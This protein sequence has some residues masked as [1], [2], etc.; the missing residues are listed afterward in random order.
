MSPIANISKID[1]L[2]I[3]TLNILR[4]YN[5]QKH[6][7]K[8]KKNYRKIGIMYYLKNLLRKKDKVTGKRI[9]P[10][11]VKSKRTKVAK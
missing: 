2:I 7:K 3:F 9:C 10:G 5:S 4:K 8:I 6:P 11:E 1:S